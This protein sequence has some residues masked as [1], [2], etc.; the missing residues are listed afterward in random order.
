MYIILL[1]MA[2]VVGVEVAMVRGK[3]CRAAGFTGYI[4]T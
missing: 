3:P 4:C 1:Y 2:G